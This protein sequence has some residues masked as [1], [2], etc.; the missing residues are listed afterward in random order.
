MA[1]SPLQKGG[2][3]RPAERVRRMSPLGVGG[4]PVSV[5]PGSPLSPLRKGGKPLQLHCVGPYPTS[6]L[7]RAVRSEVFVPF[8]PRSGLLP[9][10]NGFARAAEE[11]EWQKWAAKWSL[12]LSP[13][14]RHSPSFVELDGELATASLLNLPCGLSLQV[15]TQYPRPE[16]F[17]MTSSFSCMRPPL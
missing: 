10:G 6:C 5:F 16:V 9:T 7:Q 1:V 4:K 2:K 14:L 8:K 11:K 3:T 17:T 13:V 12:E 15:Y